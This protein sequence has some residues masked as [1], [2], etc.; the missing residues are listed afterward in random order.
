MR[1]LRK[2][3]RTRRDCIRNDIRSTVEIL[4]GMAFVERQTLKWF[5][6]LV[7][8]NPILPAATAYNKKMGICG[9]R[10]RLRRRGTGGVN[11]I[12]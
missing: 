3:V 10:E 8:M 7:K 12:Q 5:G 1:C 9:G 6:L 4:P 2:A 11:D